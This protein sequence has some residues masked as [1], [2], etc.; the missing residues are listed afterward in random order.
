MAGTEGIAAAIAE[1]LRARAIDVTLEDAHDLKSIEGYDAVIV[2]GALYGNR[3]HV[4]AAIRDPPLGRTSQGPRL[5]V[6][7]RSARRISL[8]SFTCP[9]KRSQCSDAARGRPGSHDVRWSIAR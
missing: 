9:R 8:R 4:D 1:E 5:A 6:F 2:G 7:E 3:W